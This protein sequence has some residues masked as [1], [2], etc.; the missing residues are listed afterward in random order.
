MNETFEK[1][2]FSLNS[3]KNSN[4]SFYEY[5]K[6]P[7]KFEECKEEINFFEKFHIN[8]NINN[9]IFNDFKDEQEVDMVVVNNENI[10][11]N[12]NTKESNIRLANSNINNF[13]NNSSE[14]RQDTD[15]IGMEDRKQL[16]YLGQFQQDNL[17][18]NQNMSLPQEI[19][20]EDFNNMNDCGLHGDNYNMNN[21]N[22]DY[23]NY[24]IKSNNIRDDS[25]DNTHIQINKSKQNYSEFPIHNKDT[26]HLSDKFNI[27]AYKPKNKIEKSSH[28]EDKYNMTKN[29]NITSQI[30]YQLDKIGE[31]TNVNKS[32][33]VNMLSSQTN[34]SSKLL[35]K[36]YFSQQVNSIGNI[37]AF[38]Q[39][40]EI[41]DLENKYGLGEGS[42]ECP[43]YN[44]FSE[45]KLKEEMKKYGL[46]AASVKFM[47]KTLNQIWEF[48]HISKS[49]L[50]YLYNRKITRKF[51]I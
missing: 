15:L 26:N 23:E 27:L 1:I 7:L 46:K 51:K 43:D 39:V 48:M 34:K 37:Q 13:E 3:E 10:Q 11:E 12:M 4:F 29:I 42:Y 44:S 25:N 41:T 14:V 9:M 36:E 21:S 30:D 47:V 2:D 22:L 28:G 18:P 5:T 16:G 24:S 45:E 50:F 6:N 35:T 19:S 33:V 49:N 31:Y 40:P 32:S 20:H 17:N 8:F 38:S